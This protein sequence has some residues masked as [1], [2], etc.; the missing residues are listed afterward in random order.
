MKFLSLSAIAI[1]ALTSC[2]QK[3]IKVI[4]EPSD[5]FQ[6]TRDFAKEI[7]KD[8]ALTFGLNEHLEDFVI[9]GMESMRELKEQ[10]PEFYQECASIE[11]TKERTE[12]LKSSKEFRAILKRHNI[13]PDAIKRIESLKESK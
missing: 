8:S 4:K 6:F 9:P 5:P 2:Q 11:D 7:Q 13:N 1:L 3:E 12:K 10:N